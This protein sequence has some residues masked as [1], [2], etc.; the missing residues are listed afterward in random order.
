M[1]FSSKAGFQAAAQPVVQVVPAPF[2]SSFS[3]CSAQHPNCSLTP[4]K[5]GLQLSEQSDLKIARK[6]EM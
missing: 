2:L 3:A 6:L 1:F 5:A 4:P